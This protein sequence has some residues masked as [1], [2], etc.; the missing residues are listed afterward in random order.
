MLPTNLLEQLS[1]IGVSENLNIESQGEIF[2]SET[3]TIVENPPDPKNCSA[4]I[5]HDWGDMCL[6]KIIHCIFLIFY[7]LFE[8]SLFSTLPKFS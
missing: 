6:E 3:M 7:G 2:L 1:S 4:I 5:L 8:R